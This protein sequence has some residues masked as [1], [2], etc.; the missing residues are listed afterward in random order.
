M[1]YDYSKCIKCCCYWL[2][3]TGE[4][5]EAVKGECSQDRIPSFTCDVFQP[6]EK[7][8]EKSEVRRD[9][10]PKVEVFKHRGGGVLLFIQRTLRFCNAGHLDERERSKLWYQT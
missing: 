3:L 7:E 4:A 5:K 6:I 1:K 2:N 10:M 8:G 9:Q